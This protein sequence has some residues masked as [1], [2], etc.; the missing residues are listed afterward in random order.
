MEIER[1]WGKIGKEGLF[2]AEPA[3]TDKC[4]NQYF[5]FPDKYK[6]AKVSGNGAHWFLALCAVVVV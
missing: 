2:Q 1:G 6:E 4:K 3:E 5:F